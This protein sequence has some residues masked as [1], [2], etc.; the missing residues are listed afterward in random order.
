MSHLILLAALLLYAVGLLCALRHIGIGLLASG[1]SGLATVG[2]VWG[3]LHL[4]YASDILH[5]IGF[6]DIPASVV[7]KEARFG[8]LLRYVAVHGWVVGIVYYVPIWVLAA[9]V[10]VLRRPDSSFKPTPLAAR[11]DSGPAA[12]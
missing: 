1:A 12:Q 3:A 4:A 9:L 8:W 7:A 2:F 5:A 10:R 11:L 6:V